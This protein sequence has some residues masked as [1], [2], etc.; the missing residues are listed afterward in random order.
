[1]IIIIIIII[2]KEP[3]NVQYVYLVLYEYPLRRL[4]CRVPITYLDYP[5]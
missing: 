3:Y 2:K 5:V 4:P 1:M